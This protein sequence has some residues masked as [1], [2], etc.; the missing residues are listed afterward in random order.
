MRIRHNPTGEIGFYHETIIL[1][2]FP[3]FIVIREVDN[4]FVMW[5]FMDCTVVREVP[6]DDVYL[7]NQINSQFD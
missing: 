1:Q 5:S 4:R 3:Q 6:L 2:N 7:H